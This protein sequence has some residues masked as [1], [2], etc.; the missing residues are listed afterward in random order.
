[1]NKFSIILLLLYSFFTQAQTEETFE[2]GQK[3]RTT[4]FVSQGKSFNLK[5]GFV[6]M[7]SEGVGAGSSDWYITPKVCPRTGIV[8]IIKTADKKEV[9][10]KSLSVFVSNDCSSPTNGALQIELKRNGKQVSVET[11]AINSGDVNGYVNIDFTQNGSACISADVIKFRLIGDLTT[12]R[13][14]NFKWDNGLYHALSK[15]INVLSAK[16]F[17]PKSV[18]YKWLNCTG[19]CIEIPE[20]TSRVYIAPKTG[21]YAVEVTD[22]MCSFTS[23]TKN[24]SKLPII[25]EERIED[26][27]NGQIQGASNFSSGSR[28]FNVGNDWSVETWQ[29][30][31]VTSTDWYIDNY[32]SCSNGG[33]SKMGSISSNN[34]F[35]F[36]GAWF[37]ASENCADVADGQVRVSWYKNDRFLDSK[38][39]DVNSLSSVERS[40][41]F[42]YLDFK[43]DG[44]ASLFVD[45]LTFEPLGNLT[46]LSMDDFSWSTRTGNST[47]RMGDIELM[48]EQLSSTTEKVKLSL[49][50]NPVVDEL[51]LQHDGMN[52]GRISISNAL[53]TVIKEVYSQ[54][55]KTTID[56]SELGS[57]MYII[58]VSSGEN[59][60]TMTFVK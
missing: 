54:G 20:E 40:N 37:Y 57:G 6:I 8:G 49:Y 59:N 44:K 28:Q 32:S 38:I 34:K 50:P 58:Q 39:Y 13:I 56:V 17:S 5:R 11:Y 47:A 1:M 41:G 30:Y 31:G 53:G 14:D 25:S 21:V 15:N 10:M 27:E 26:F 29:Y 23:A 60:S 2:T 55:N 48:E 46:Y 19:T 16:D 22:G 35:F 4:S 3:H 12:L 45:S 7:N 52:N 36:N 33:G 43:L 42:V 18:D 24:V 51:T 9:Y